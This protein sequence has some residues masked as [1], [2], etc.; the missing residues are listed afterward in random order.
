LGFSRY[1]VYELIK[2]HRDGSGLLTDLSPRRSSGGKGTLRLS[3][4]VEDLVR[5]LVR[6]QFLTGRSGR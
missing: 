1:Q 6:K 5:E 2:R 3:Y 4:A